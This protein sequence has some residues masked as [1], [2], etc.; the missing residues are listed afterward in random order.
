MVNVAKGVLLK[1]SDA[2][3]KQFIKHLDE[4]SALG[5]KFIIHDL[6]DT[7]LFVQGDVTRSLQM[8]LDE[9]M[10]RNSYSEFGGDA[11]GPRVR[12]E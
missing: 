7:H 3:I 2:A 10:A 5:M 4:S 9:L 8:K 6:D 11:A 12:T 1:C